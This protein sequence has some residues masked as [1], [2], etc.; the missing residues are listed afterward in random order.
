MGEEAPNPVRVAFQAIFSFL[1]HRTGRPFSAEMPW[2][3]GP[4]HCGQSSAAKGAENKRNPART[5]DW[6]RTVSPGAGGPHRQA[7]SALS[8]FVA[9][10]NLPI[11]ACMTSSATVK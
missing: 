8:F 1:V 6:I 7:R 9:V 11:P 4:R 2:L 10:G 3:E 5:T